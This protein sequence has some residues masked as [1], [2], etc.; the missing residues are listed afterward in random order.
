MRE[1]GKP[2]F[3][4]LSELKLRADQIKSTNFHI[5]ER[6]ESGNATEEFTI[7]EYKRLGDIALARVKFKNDEYNQ[8]PGDF[9]RKIHNSEP[10]VFSKPNY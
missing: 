9:L 4:D 6:Y 1:N 3:W 10:I 2:I 5:D 8:Y 7:F